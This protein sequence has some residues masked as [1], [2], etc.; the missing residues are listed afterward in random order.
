MVDAAVERWGRL[1]VLYNN[2]AV[3]MSGRLL[4]CTDDEW[5]LTM[6]TNLDAIFW[7][8][9]AAIPRMLDGG[10]GSIINTASV[11]GLIGSAGYCAYGAAKAGLVALTR[12]IAVEYGPAIRANVIAP[13]S[14]D[15]PRFRKVA[16]DMG[17]DRE[18]VPRDAPQEH[19]AAPPRH[20]RRRRR[21]RA[22]PRLGAVGLHDRR[23]HPGRRRTGGAAMTTVAIVTG[24][25]VGP[26]RGD[27]RAAGR[28]R[29]PRRRRRPRRRGRRARGRRR[30][31][32]TAVDAD[33][34]RT[35]RRRAHG[36]RTA[37]AL[38]DAQGARAVGRGR[39]PRQHRRHDRRGVAGGPRHEP[40]G[41]VPLHARSGAAHDRAPAAARSS[42]SA[43]RSARSSPPG[44]PAY[45]AS[46]FALTNLC[47]QVA[48]EHAAD[49]VRV[50]V[51][52]PSACDTGLFV[53]MAESTG[54]RAGIER[55]VTSNVPMGRLGTAREVCDAVAFFASDASSY[56]SRARCS[57]ST[58]AWPRGG[59]D[60]RRTGAIFDADGARHRAGRRVHALDRRAAA[61]GPAGRHADG[62]RAAT[63]SC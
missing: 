36:R 16:D 43:R 24:G 12:Q 54:D 25:G 61:D 1:D 19:P 51:V 45:C 3:Q 8:C 23:R 58:A 46:K 5:D 57:R 17:M 33:V 55:M 60:A 39:D 48:I 35:R 59:C 56:T 38:G 30:S 27:L 50:N 21:D 9:R 7:A 62:R 28:R 20:G 10:G 31:A 63:S 29:L 6:A 52:A 4:E 26:G 37:A 22:V 15:T 42:P 13:G 32:A 53:R 34:R 40:Q 14:I 11:L 47:K 49:G 2:A 18:V 41:P 44:Y